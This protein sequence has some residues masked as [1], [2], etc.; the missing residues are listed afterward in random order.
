MSFAPISYNLFKMTPTELETGV[1]AERAWRGYC[2]DGWIHTPVE[3]LQCHAG[4]GKFCPCAQKKFKDEYR[5]KRKSE[6][7]N[8]ELNKHKW[9]EMQVL[10]NRMENT[11]RLIGENQK[12]LGS[13]FNQMTTV[14]R[15]GL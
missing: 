2:G 13:L 15:R 7:D 10:I 8:R 11:Q 3:C 1:E 9:E 12:V 4:N 5:E 14:M 6:I